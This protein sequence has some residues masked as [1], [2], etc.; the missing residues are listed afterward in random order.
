MSRA[1][2]HLPIWHTRTYV[3]APEN[4][5][6]HWYPNL[7][8]HQSMTQAQTYGQGHADSVVRSQRWRTVANSAA[9]VQ[10]ELRPGRRVLDVG[11][12]PATITADIARL[13]APGRVVG[14]D[15]SAAVIE[16]GRTNVAGLDNV[17]LRVGEAT[18]LPFGDATFDVVHAHAVL[19]HI[20][21][22]VRALR[23]MLRVTRPGGVVAVRDADYGGAMWWPEDPWLERWRE[24]YVAV[25]RDNGADPYAGRRLLARAHEAG[26]ARVT[27]S[28]SI[29]CHATP[30]ERAWWGGMWADRILHSRI[31]EQAVAGGHAT[32]ADLEQISQAW[33]AWA[34]DPDGWFAIPHGEIV[35]RV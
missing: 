7:G 14:I 20:P 12:G 13:V 29:W 15:A 2:T 22:A 10:G 27:P 35:C 21:D 34:V 9:Y 11:C 3:T 1:A 30:E 6:W 8:Y 19:M 4:A 16:E 25:A 31:A 32:P 28:A 18:A 24:V 5:A 26:A 33:R 17:E 23:E